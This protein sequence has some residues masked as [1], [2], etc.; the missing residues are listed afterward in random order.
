[1]QILSRELKHIAIIMDGN[2]R[3]ALQKGME[4]EDGHVQGAETAKNIIQFCSNIQLPYLTLYAFSKE[5]WDRPKKEVSS[6]MR[7]LSQTI[8]KDLQSLMDLNISL[9]IAGEKNRLPLYV[10]K[11]LEI[12]VQKTA[13][14]T[15]MK[16]VLALSYSGR[17]E[18]VSS[19]NKI[20]ESKNKNINEDLVE[21]HLYCPEVPSPDILIRTGGEKRISNFLIWQIAYSELFFE[22]V[23]WPD[24]RAENLSNI[25]ERFYERKRTFGNIE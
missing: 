18:I 22:D 4:R 7:L 2:G 11:S 5:N 19:L 9:Q 24:F 25:I 10:K 16:M 13:K 14:N 1:M 21:K 20:I 8:K 3:W 12:A 23:Q 15:G 17:E 6:I